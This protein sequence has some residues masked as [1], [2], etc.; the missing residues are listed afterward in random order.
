ME[1]NCR[2]K[3]NHLHDTGLRL[4]LMEFKLREQ[5]DIPGK[6]PV[7]STNGKYL[8]KAGSLIYEA[9]NTVPE[10]AKEHRRKRRVIK[11]AFGH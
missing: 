2:E 7:H 10:I 8:A 6:C 1:C 11:L 5:I 4:P 3:L 9:I